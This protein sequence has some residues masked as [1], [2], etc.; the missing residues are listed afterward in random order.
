M[1]VV[2]HGN[3]TDTIVLKLPP[4]FIGLVPEGVQ[5]ESDPVFEAWDKSTGISIY[6][7]QIIDRSNLLS[8]D[9]SNYTTNISTIV[10]GSNTGDQDLSGRIPYTGANGNVDLGVHTLHVERAYANQETPIASTELATKGYADSLAFTGAGGITPTIAHNDTISKEG[11]GGGHWYHLSDTANAVI[12]NITESGSDIVPLGLA[13]SSSGISSGIDG[14]AYVVLTWTAIVSNTFDHYQVEYKKSSYTYYTP[15]STQSSTIIIEGLTPNTS[16]NFRLASVNRY[17]T[18]SAFSADLILTTPSDSI[19]PATVGGVSATGITQAVLLRWT[20]NTDVDLESYNIYRYTSDTSASSSPIGNIKGNVYVDNG[21]SVNTTYYYWIKAKDTSGNLSASYS[22]SVYATTQKLPA[23]DIA[24][25]AATQIVLQGA[26]TLA[27]WLSPGVTTIDGSKITTGTVTLQQLNFTPIEG[28]RII[29]TINASS[30][31]I[32]IDADNF[33][34][35][36]SSVFTS[37]VGGSFTSA[38]SVPR[39]R[40]FPDSDTG[41]EIVDDLGNFS[42]RALVGGANIGDVIIGNWAGNQGIYYDKSSNSTSFAGT[43]LASAGN[44]GGWSINGTAIV[45]DTGADGTS[46]GMAPLDYPFYSGK[47][48]SNRSTANFRVNTSG[49]VWV[50][51]LY[52]PT[53]TTDYLPHQTS[54]GYLSDSIISND[55]TS[56]TVHG[57]LTITS[58]NYGLV[59]PRMTTTQRNSLSPINGMMIYNTSTDH[60]NMYAG[61]TW[62]YLNATV[63]Q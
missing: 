43:I 44:I 63:G 28:G 19:A 61:G 30:E 16:Y 31:R 29:A 45:K 26:T 55:I 49:S 11:G 39:I 36:G 58:T 15:L 56:A 38:N 13:L 32:Q 21:L 59:L 12:P 9:G 10:T 50:N 7:N 20:H 33:S 46:S 23:T 35:S 51:D 62:F 34:I 5:T 8:T 24:N 3:E 48:Y 47:T 41:I 22:T 6:E 4:E 52:I 1:A 40:I 60:I 18:S 53:L 17:G 54:S 14:L 42:F 25:L 2:T 37:K 57:G 27:S